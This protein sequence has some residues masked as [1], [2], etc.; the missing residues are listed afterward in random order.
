MTTLCL[1][2][3]M[4]QVGI[5]ATAQDISPILQI[6]IRS[7]FAAI[8]V[9][10]LMLARR[11][12][13]AVALAC[14]R[15]GLAA[16]VLFAL[17]YLLLGAGLRYTSAAHAVIFLYTGPLFAALGLHL[18]LPSERLAPVQWLGV[19]MAFA[20]IAVAFALGARPSA[21]TANAKALLGDAFCLAAGAAWGATTVVVRCSGL[22]KM[23]A[24]QTL[25]YQLT[26]GFV[27]LLGAAFLLEQLSFA[28][29]PMVIGNLVFQSIIVS[30]ASLLAWFHLLRRYQASGLGI[31]S[32]MTP[33]FGVVL[34]A[35]FLDEHIAPGFII[36]AGLALAG[37]MLVSSHSWWKLRK[38]RN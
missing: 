32:F 12:K 9:A 18:K 7:G 11:E 23:P 30:F 38:G 25:L 15:P 27:M 29:T 10:I 17:E 13:L 37:I 4:Q 31:F 34:G 35:W 28:S 8:L 26:G 36:G 6:A 24:T 14:W 22:A 5:K 21:E 2:W 33:L 3:S 1:I 19:A 16:G 20:G